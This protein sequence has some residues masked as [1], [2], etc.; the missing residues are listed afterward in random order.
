MDSSIVSVCVCARVRVRDVF[1]YSLKSFFVTL[2][3]L[4]V[5]GEIVRDKFLHRGFCASET[6]IWARILLN[7]FWTPEFRTRILGSNFLVLFFPGKE[8]P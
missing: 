8:A 1:L 3:Q 7:E 4:A 6:R 5:N 2:F